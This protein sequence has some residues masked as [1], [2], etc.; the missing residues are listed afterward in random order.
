MKVKRIT[1]IIFSLLMTL[2]MISITCFSTI[3]YAISEDTLRQSDSSI[4]PPLNYNLQA[5]ACTLNGCSVGTYGSGYSGEGYVEFIDEIGDSMTAVFD[6]ESGFHTL[7]FRYSQGEYGTNTLSLYINSEFVKQLEFDYTGEWNISWADAYVQL[8]DLPEGELSVELRYTEGDGNVDIDYIECIPRGMMPQDEVGY[9]TLSPDTLYTTE[10]GQFDYLLGRDPFQCAN[11][12]AYY[13]SSSDLFIPDMI[14]GLRLSSSKISFSGRDDIRSVTFGGP[15][16]SLGISGSFAGCTGLESIKVLP[17]VSQVVLDWY[18]QMGDYG[19][20]TDHFINIYASFENCTALTEV[21]FPACTA[22]NGSYIEARSFRNCTALPEIT[23]DGFWRI[24]EGAF[25]GCTSLDRV[26]LTRETISI[27]AYAFGYTENEDGT[28]SRCDGLTIYGVPGTAAETYAME[29]DIPFVSIEVE[30]DAN[31]DG[32]H[33]V[34]DLVYV[35]RYMLGQN[36]FTLIS[37]GAVNADHTG[38]GTIDS[39]DLIQMR[40]SLID[41]IH[42]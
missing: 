15:S 31:C 6:I 38:D 9:N 30:G 14:G 32:K 39:F 19:N 2:L 41:L 10:D 16:T 22:D 5:E 26:V 17:E 13:G 4:D 7:K 1:A 24:G 23:L 28:F 21:S 33:N 18:E 20:L 36:E 27:G 3:A 12:T 40:K 25:A 34:S 29:N 35:S 42:E 37:Q 8:A 11:I